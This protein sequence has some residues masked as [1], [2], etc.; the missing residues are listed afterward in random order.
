MRT[1]N[2]RAG[3]VVQMCLQTSD[4]PGVTLSSEL[5]AVSRKTAALVP[6]IGSSAAAEALTGDDAEFWGEAIGYLFSAAIR[7][8]IP[9][10]APVGEPLEIDT[11][12]N[13]FKFSVPPG[14]ADQLPL[15]QVWTDT[16]WESISLVSAVSANR[17]TLLA[18]SLFA[19]TGPTR[20]REEQGRYRTFNPLFNVMDDLM[21]TEAIFITHE[22]AWA[23][24]N[25]L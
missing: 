25:T 10:K 4:Q 14:T 11:G 2:E 5:A 22:H 17:A 1:W 20:A 3:E 9:K 15:E 19:A 13:K 18:T 8:C 23:F 24:W 6:S 21:R 16:A 7:R 12:T